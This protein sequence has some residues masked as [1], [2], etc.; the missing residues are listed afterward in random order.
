MLYK[1]TI[2]VLTSFIST[3]FAFA[4]FFAMTGGNSS[5]VFSWHLFELTMG[6]SLA[7]KVFKEYE[8][9]QNHIFSIALTYSLIFVVF[10]VVALLLFYVLDLVNVKVIKVLNVQKE[11]RVA[12]LAMLWSF[13]NLLTWQ[14]L[15][16]LI[17][18]VAPLYLFPIF[19][20]YLNLDNELLFTVFIVILGL[21]HIVFYLITLKRDNLEKNAYINWFSAFVPTAKTFFYSVFIYFLLD[22]VI[23]VFDLSDS[24]IILVAGAV[25]VAILFWEPL[26]QII[27]VSNIQSNQYWKVVLKRLDIKYFKM[28]VVL[29]SRYLKV[30]FLLSP[31]AFMA[32]AL[33]LFDL[34]LLPQV[35][36]N[37]KSGYYSGHMQEIVFQILDKYYISRNILLNTSVYWS[38]AFGFIFIAFHNLFLGKYIVLTNLVLEEDRV[39]MQ[40]KA[41]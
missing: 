12:M 29:Y 19:T 18:L 39:L 20:E 21:E 32:I 6:E 10:F 37:L 33:I 41:S 31:L 14:F 27:L 7:G 4:F 24:S 9:F 17:M 38:M 30:L 13:K 23:W 8:F 34:F 40:I 1:I 35:D 11:Y 36:S 15:C 28:I 26:T 5:N 3:V 25:F 2:S 16:L 22:A